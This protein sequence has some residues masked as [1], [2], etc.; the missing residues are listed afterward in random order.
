MDLVIIREN[1]EGEYSHIE[2]EVCRILKLFV[3]SLLS[4]NFLQST[5]SR[6]D[7][8]GTGIMCPSEGAFYLSELTSQTIG[9]VVRISLLSKTIQPD[10]SNPI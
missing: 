6:K 1:T 10:Q 2:H 4:I 8:F 9:L 5:L 7:T 3:K